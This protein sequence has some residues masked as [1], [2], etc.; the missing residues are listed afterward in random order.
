MHTNT[1]TDL[2]PL[3]VSFNSSRPLGAGFSLIGGFTLDMASISALYRLYIHQHLYWSLCESQ[4]I[5]SS[6]ELFSDSY[7]LVVYLILLHAI[8]SMHPGCTCLVV[9]LSLRSLKTQTSHLSEHNSS[10]FE[11]F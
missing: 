8:I 5:A 6:T 1:C 9:I 7:I 3:T 10:E 11:K 4:G 2:P